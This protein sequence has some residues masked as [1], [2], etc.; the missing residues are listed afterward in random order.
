MVE[1]VEK[2]HVN[3]MYLFYICYVPKAFYLISL[4]KQFSDWEDDTRE[5][6]RPKEFWEDRLAGEWAAL[7]VAVGNDGWSSGYAGHFQMLTQTVICHKPRILSLSTW[8][9]LFASLKSLLITPGP[10]PFMV[11]ELPLQC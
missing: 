3:H 8:L 9:L 6:P 2:L 11:N 5:G 10:N 4:E 7:V 1:C